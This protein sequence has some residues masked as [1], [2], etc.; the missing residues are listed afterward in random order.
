MFDQCCES[1]AQKQIKVAFLESASCG[2]LAYRFSLSPLSGKILIGSLVSYDLSVKENILDVPAQLIEKYTA[3]SMQ[4]TQA[5]LKKGTTF[6]RADLYV[7][8]TGLLKSGGSETPE[9]PVG[10][11]FYVI[12]FKEKHYCYRCQFDGLPEEKL[13]QLLNEICMHISSII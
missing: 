10:T 8:C 1:L 5:M 11:F 3:E 7:A 2:Y 6:F 9:K 4:V 13:E 12:Q